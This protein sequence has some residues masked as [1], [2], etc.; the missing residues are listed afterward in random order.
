MTRLAVSSR[1]YLEG[2]DDAEEEEL[3]GEPLARADAVED[4]VG[5]DLGQDDAE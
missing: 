4:H 5:G 2:A 3:Q 1:V